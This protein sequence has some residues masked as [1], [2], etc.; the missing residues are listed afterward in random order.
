MRTLIRKPPLLYA[1]AAAALALI[2]WVDYASGY[3]FGFFVFYF[4]PVATVAWW[5]SRRAGAIFALASGACWYLSDRLSGTPYS[6]TLY[7]YWE[8][9]MRTVSYLLVGLA[10]SQVRSALRRQQDLLRIVSHDLRTPLAVLTGQAELLARRAE[11]GSWVASRAESILRVTHRMATMIDD[12]VDAAR[13]QSRR[14]PLDLRP[15]ELEP[16]LSELLHRMS[17]A[18]PC[19]R[20]DLQV[21]GEGLAVQADPGRLERIIVNLLSNALRYSP[22]PSRVQVEVSPSG[23]RVIVAV[24]D[25]GPGIAEEDRPHLFEQYYRG[26]ASAGSE[27]LGLGLHSAELLVRAHGGSIRAE[28]TRGGGATFLIEL[29][30][31]EPPRRAP[32]ESG[33]RSRVADQRR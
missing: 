26:R 7:V 6:R 30:A 23:G 11:P 9:L 10:L 2:T 15:V 33:V 1:L 13:Y 21:R 18:L 16:F 19:E 17:A 5:G 14:L 12:L 25:H 4:L 8:T 20:V 32:G 24:V 28:A 29:P 31:A 27:G 3:E 22:A